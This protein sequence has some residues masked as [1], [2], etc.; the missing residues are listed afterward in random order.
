MSK[1]AVVYIVGI[2]LMFSFFPVLVLSGVYL[3]ERLPQT[4]YMAF[5]GSYFIFSILAGTFVITKFSKQIRKDQA[6]NIEKRLPSLVQAQELDHAQL[7]I[8]E[9]TQEEAELKRQKINTY[10]ITAYGLLIASF[11]L[12]GGLIFISLPVGVYL[13]MKVDKLKIEVKSWYYKSKGLNLPEVEN[14]NL[15]PKS[16][17][18][19]IYSVNFIQNLFLKYNIYETIRFDDLLSFD[20]KKLPVEL[21]DFKVTTGGKNSSTYSYI[22]LKADNPD[23]LTG[24][25][26]AWSD[27]CWEFKL[28]DKIR[29]ESVVFDKHFQT[30]SSSQ[31]EAR[32]HLKTNVMQDM[33]DLY[34]ST[35]SKR[36]VF[37]FNQSQIYVFFRVDKDPFELNYDLSLNQSSVADQLLKD[38]Q[39]GLK[40]FDDFWLD[41]K[42]F[43]RTN[44]N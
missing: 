20:Y 31:L 26:A 43:L 44:N 41:R 23:R 8:Q 5:A 32:L 13:L 16:S 18:N 22:C 6:K 40:I 12:P 25:T 34:N 19:Q 1:N 15:V 9:L 39:L 30:V 38:I 28:S 33:I 21:V 36:V 37:Y 10:N 3:S 42:A 7:K 24:E 4:V 2:C 17:F 35:K 27:S 14:L 11:I 29:T